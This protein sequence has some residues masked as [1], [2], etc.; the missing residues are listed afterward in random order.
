MFRLQLARTVLLGDKKRNSNDSFRTMSTNSGLGSGQGKNKGK[1]TSYNINSIYKG[2]SVPQ[3]KSSTGQRQ[4]GMQSLGKVASTRRMPPPAQLPSLK[5]ESFGNDPNI[6]LV[7]TG[8]SGWGEKTAPNQPTTTE[9]S[10]SPVQ[11]SSTTKP[12]DSSQVSSVSSSQPI[13]QPPAPTS[14]AASVAVSSP[15][16]SV[17]KSWSSVTIG[18]RKMNIH[19]NRFDQ[20]S[21]AFAQEFPTLDTEKEDEENAGPSLRPQNVAVWRGGG[22]RVMGSGG[23]EDGSNGDVSAPD[24]HRIPSVEDDGSGLQQM[25]RNMMPSNMQG[26]YGRHMI[27]SQSFNP[28]RHYNYPM[29]G[30]RSSHFS[31]T[32][33]E[34]RQFSAKDEHGPTIVKEKEIEE[35]GKKAESSGEGKW[36]DQ[37][38]E[39]DYSEKLVFSD[40]EEENDV[41][42][43]KEP[44]AI[45]N[46]QEIPKR[47]TNAVSREAWAPQY[48]MRQ[49]M[50]DRHWANAYYPMPSPQVPSNADLDNEDDKYYNEKRKAQREH[51]DENVTRARKRK[52]E[53]V[54]KKQS[55]EEYSTSD[56]RDRTFSDGSDKSKGKSTGSKSGSQRYQ[57]QDPNFNS[58]SR[59]GW[60]GSVWHQN[61]PSGGRQ[62]SSHQGDQSDNYREEGASFQQDPFD[63]DRRTVLLRKPASNDKKENRKPKEDSRN[64]SGDSKAKGHIAP[65]PVPQSGTELETYRGKLTSL[66]FKTSATSE[67]KQLDSEKRNT[68]KKVK[69]PR[70]TS[71]REQSEK[72]TGPV[73][74]DSPKKEEKNEQKERREEEKERKKSERRLF[75]RQKDEQN[76]K[77]TAE[78]TDKNGGRGSNRARRGSSRGNSANTYY[79][80]RQ[81][82][83][84]GRE[85]VRGGRARPATY[86]ASASSRRR[87]DYNNYY[88]EPEWPEPSPAPKRRER[89]TK[90]S[91]KGERSQKPKSER[92][93]VEKSEKSTHRDADVKTKDEEKEKKIADKPKDDFVVRGEPSRRGRGNGRGFR[94]SRSDRGR[95]NEETREPVSTRNSKSVKDSGRSG[96]RSGR[97]KN[98]SERRG[99]GRS[100]KNSVKKQSSHDVD[101]WETASESSVAGGEKKQRDIGGDKESAGGKKTFTSQRPPNGIAGN[102]KR[103]SRGPL[104]T[105]AAV[106]RIREQIRQNPSTSVNSSATT[107]APSQSMGN[108]VDALANI[109]LN[110]IASVVVVDQIPDG[111]GVEEDGDLDGD[112]DFQRVTY[113]KQPKAKG[114]SV[115]LQPQ[116]VKKEKKDVATKTKSK[117]ETK[118]LTKLPPRLRPKGKKKTEKPPKVESKSPTQQPQPVTPVVVSTSS[119]STTPIVMPKIETWDNNMAVNI[120]NTA[121]STSNSTN[122][123]IQQ[124]APAPAVNAWDKPIKFHT[125]KEESPKSKPEKVEPTEKVSSKSGNSTKQQG[126]SG[127]KKLKNSRPP[128]PPRMTKTRRSDEKK[129]T[130]KIAPI[131]LPDNFNDSSNVGTFTFGSTIS[132]EKEKVVEEVKSK[133]EE[134]VPRGESP[135]DEIL[136]SNIAAVKTVWEKDCFYQPTTVSTTVAETKVEASNAG[137][138]NSA[139]AV[140]SA[141]QPAYDVTPSLKSPHTVAGEPTNVC[142]VRPQPVPMTSSTTVSPPIPSQVQY[143]QHPQTQANAY[144]PP[145]FP[146]PPQQ[147]TTANVYP[148]E[149]YQYRQPQQPQQAPA[150]HFGKSPALSYGQLVNS[151]PQQTQ[152]LLQYDTGQPLNHN[153]QHSNIIG[154]NLV[155]HIPPPHHSSYYSPTTPFY[156]QPGGNSIQAPIQQLSATQYNFTS[157]FSHQTLQQ[158]QMQKQHHHQQAFSLKSPPIQTHQPSLFGSVSTSSAGV[159]HSTNVYNANAFPTT[160]PPPMPQSMHATN[161]NIPPPNYHRPQRVTPRGNGAGMMR[162]GTLM[163]NMGNTQ[164]VP[165]SLTPQQRATGHFRNHPQNPPSTGGSSLIKEQQARQRRE[166]LQHAQNFLNTTPGTSN[167]ASEETVPEIAEKVD[168]VVAAPVEIET[169]LAEIDST[170]VETQLPSTE[171]KLASN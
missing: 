163:M 1:Y 58:G 127:Q 121:T 27:M 43:K 21:A 70:E 17:Q 102:G 119:S 145:T 138:I 12:T 114:Q 32:H 46:R 18:N 158:Q 51:F 97:G 53:L 103:G 29:Q 81:S 155:R 74:K 143:F 76:T 128:R 50:P 134:K 140:V 132:E 151:A 4:H 168:D 44:E 47:P 16:Q 23:E 69:E 63:E 61:N 75:K 41:K 9:Q 141:P 77:S 22:G 85:F 130:N 104:Q 40:E 78:S 31:Q 170:P 166:L 146:A 71:K 3:Q 162:P 160:K 123:T 11:S 15:A 24:R 94:G 89:K 28:P 14:V 64:K 56:G 150:P 42:S 67:R 171:T 30:V 142:K 6:T 13:Q 154:S 20:Q 45:S 110:N 82:Y 34:P 109:D 129:K 10:R 159:S 167:I 120:P 83:G 144:Q 35:L 39:V 7:P 101:E 98:T 93:K 117:T 5:S 112:G 139:L 156:Q 80:S 118:R 164:R 122:T 169:A 2:T 72:V 62:I 90:D 124:L 95:N 165:F 73:S 125:V 88:Y 52:E 8:R 36:A 66:K 116:P 137:V 135:N 148:Q 25:Q 108:K 37:G 57:R 48:G 105:D 60:S 86:S 87:R 113:K 59:G 161:I 100:S 26:N 55:S 38:G 106:S 149:F 91:D 33:F 126:E 152:L 19:G 153:N 68:E 54:K 133:G 99:G 65:V 92:N 84:R 147:T 136:K 131:V 157:P 96:G 107:N 111:G 79:E 115:E 49:S